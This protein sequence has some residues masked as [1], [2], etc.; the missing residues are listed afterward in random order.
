MYFVFGNEQ[1]VKSAGVL[2]DIVVIIDDYISAIREDYKIIRNHI[3]TLDDINMRIEKKIS[4]TKDKNK[5]G[6]LIIRGV[7]EKMPNFIYFGQTNSSDYEKKLK[8]VRI[9]YSHFINYVLYVREAS[10]N[11]FDDNQYRLKLESL[12]SKLLTADSIDIKHYFSTMLF[13]L[14]SERGYSTEILLQRLVEDPMVHRSVANISDFYH[15]KLIDLFR[16]LKDPKININDK[17]CIRPLSVLVFKLDEEKFSKLDQNIF[18]DESLIE[19]VLKPVF[20]KGIELYLI[21]HESISNPST[22]G[23]DQLKPTVVKRLEKLQRKFNNLF[24]V[25]LSRNNDLLNILRDSVIDEKNANDTFILLGDI[26]GKRISSLDFSDDILNVKY[27]FKYYLFKLLKYQDL[28]GV[29]DLSI[30]S[31]LLFYIHTCN[32]D[33]NIKIRTNVTDANN[34]YEQKHKRQILELK[35]LFIRVSNDD[36]HTGICDLLEVLKIMMNIQSFDYRLSSTREILSELENKQSNE[37]FNI[38]TKMLK[39][40]LNGVRD[41][42]EICL[43]LAQSF[44]IHLL[45]DVVEDKSDALS[46]LCSSNWNL[47]LLIEKLNDLNKT[48][49]IDQDL[50]PGF[51]IPYYLS[52]KLVDD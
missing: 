10:G 36:N 1:V 5:I 38:K 31:R 33:T 46:K 4:K 42:S 51:S 45:K 37:Y 50:T 40:V 7:E 47:N 8:I 32:D 52:A 27:C 21:T 43:K 41:E 35:K 13:K 49:D 22:R 29:P 6:Y 26:Y 16:K 14:V 30:F 15:K 11:N 17:K 3:Q 28:N 48:F 34:A 2:Y 44:N 39:K 19:L 12:Q 20:D 25:I 9:F 24:T 18:D 23:N